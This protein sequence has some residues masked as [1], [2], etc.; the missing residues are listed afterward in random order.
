MCYHVKR[1]FSKTCYYYDN[2][3]VKTQYMYNK[4]IWYVVVIIKL[5]Y[6]WCNTTYSITYIL[7]IVI[8]II[9]P[10]F[11]YTCMN[12]CNE[13]Y[14]FFLFLFVNS[15]IIY[16]VNTVCL[17]CPLGLL[18]FWMCCLIIIIIYKCT[19]NIRIFIIKPTMLIRI[20]TRY[21]Y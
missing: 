2:C 13:T 17:L 5:H 4:L 12:C 9:I 21:F 16:V 7:S 8:N 18:A 11:Y 1:N 20:S 15:W 3:P 19:S 6:K 14:D 10:I